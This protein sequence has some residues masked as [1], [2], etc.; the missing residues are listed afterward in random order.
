M[1]TEVHNDQKVTQFIT[2]VIFFSVTFFKNT[3]QNVSFNIS[4]YRMF[5]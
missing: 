5:E 2:N 1:L 3:F 4:I